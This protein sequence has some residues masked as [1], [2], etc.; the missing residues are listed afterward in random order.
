MSTTP[1]Q[2]DKEMPFI[3]ESCLF[4]RVPLTLL[5]LQQKSNELQ[6]E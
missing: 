2:I 6:E 3:S 1:E 4:K 5:V